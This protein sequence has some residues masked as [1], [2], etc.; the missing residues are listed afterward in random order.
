[1]YT[2]MKPDLSKRERQAMDAIY[3]HGALSASQL[4][5]LLPGAPSY[6]ATRILL[7][8]LVAKDLLTF[9]NE[10]N[11]YI[12]SAKVPRSTAGQAA[13]ERLVE[14]FFDGSPTSTFSALLGISSEKLSADEL[15]E[16]E[17]MIAKAKA[18]GGP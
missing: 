15:Q 17:R 14:T 9:T 16:L 2:S 4:Q 10:Q 7:R 1:M 11:R 18:D 12:Y 6:S 8:R 13:L 5:A 3:A